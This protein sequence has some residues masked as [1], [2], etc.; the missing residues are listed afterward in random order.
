MSSVTINFLYDAK[1]IAEWSS[2]ATEVFEANFLQ[3]E[4]VYSIADQSANR[5]GMNWYA[6]VENVVQTRNP[7]I[8]GQWT[9]FDRKTEK[10]NP[11]KQFGR[12]QRKAAWSG[13]S[14]EQIRWSSLYRSGELNKNSYPDLTP[15]ERLDTPLGPFA[16]PLPPIYNDPED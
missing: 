7:S 9:P 6:R 5:S 4:D 2:G 10:Y 14:G 8:Q 13:Q 3:E 16:D 1:I 11:R 15:E 12:I